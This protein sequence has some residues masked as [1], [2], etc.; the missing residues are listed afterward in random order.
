M[1]VGQTDFKRQANEVGWFP[2]R[3][4]RLDPRKSSFDGLN[5]LLTRP[6][7]PLLSGAILDGLD[8]RSNPG[9]VGITR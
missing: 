2:L 9:R 5:D 3:S 7:V 4:L 1:Y 8:G 6:V